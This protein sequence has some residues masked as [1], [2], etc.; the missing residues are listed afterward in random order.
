[1]HIHCRQ[2]RQRFARADTIIAGDHPHL[3]RYG[4]VLFLKSAYRAA[5]KGVDQHQHAVNVGMCL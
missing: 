4:D 1:M 5:G 2:R 3:F